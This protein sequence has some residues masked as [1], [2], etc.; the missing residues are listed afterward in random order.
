MPNKIWKTCLRCYNINIKY[1]NFP[2]IVFR[3]TLGQCL[4]C[5]ICKFQCASYACELVHL[6]C[7]A[8]GVSFDI[9]F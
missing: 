9:L 4:Y 8:Q 1:G 3:L 6:I 7:V 2:I 5:V